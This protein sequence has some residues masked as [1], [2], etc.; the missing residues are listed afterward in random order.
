MDLST[1]L[2]AAAA[3]AASLAVGAALWA[4][5]GRRAADAARRDLR[6]AP[7]TPS[8]AP[9]A[10]Q[11]SAEAFETALIAARAT[12]RRG[13][14][15]GE[16]SLARLRRAAGRGAAGHGAAPTR[17]AWSPGRRA[18]PGPRRR[19]EGAVETGAPCAFEA[20]RPGRRRRGRGPRGRRAGVAAAVARW[21]AATPACPAPRGWRPSST[22]A[23]TPAWI[24]GADGAPVFAN[25]PGWTPP[26]PTASRRRATGG[27][28]FDRGADDLAARGR[29]RR[30]AARGGA[31]GRGRR[32]P[33]RLPPH[34][35]AA[36]GRR[37]RRLV[38]GRHRGRG[39]RARA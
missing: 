16:E 21:P 34:R 15:A 24:A 37:G 10:A 17:D 29:P 39:G 20:R 14:S 1:L 3:G 4:L 30:R 23:P 22:R 32:A 11:A 6:P 12:A 5:V 13:W 38:G 31:L 8:A 27:L 9:H 28:T 26:A 19:A 7:P 33:P 25:R 35:P 18:R 36:G 2:L